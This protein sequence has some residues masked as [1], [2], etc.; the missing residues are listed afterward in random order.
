MKIFIEDENG[1]LVRVYT[2][3][4]AEKKVPYSESYLRTMADTGKLPAW[5]PSRDWLITLPDEK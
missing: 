2:I 5:K 4:D 1:K 3:R